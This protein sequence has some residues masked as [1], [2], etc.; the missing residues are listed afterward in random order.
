[1]D[2]YKLVFSPFSELGLDGLDYFIIVT[3]NL[4]FAFFKKEKETLAFVFTSV[5]V[6]QGLSML[7]FHLLIHDYSRV[8]CVNSGHSQKGSF[9]TALPSVEEINKSGN[10]SNLPPTLANKE[11]F[12]T[13]CNNRKKCI[14]LV[15]MQGRPTDIRMTGSASSA[16]GAGVY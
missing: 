5:V 7:V 6:L 15:S 9:V 14:F 1:M 2:C 16:P 3:W 4:C 13:Q 8:N 12:H 11:V 10:N